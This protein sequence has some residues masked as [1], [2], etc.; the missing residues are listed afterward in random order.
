MCKNDPRPPSASDTAQATFEAA[1][2][3]LPGLFDIT[4]KAILPNEMATLEA[5]KAVQPGYTQLASDILKGPGSQLI[6][7]VLDESKKI[8]TEFFAARAAGGDAMTRLLSSIDLSGLLSGSEAAE[9]ERNLNRVDTGTG[10]TVG[11]AINT[12]KNINEYGT[13]STAKKEKQQQIG[14]EALGAAAGFLP[15]SRVG[16]DP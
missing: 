12:A 4:N 3:Y 6:G 9:M 15:A 10:N 5:T 11:S 8:D 13:A 2:K 7:G 1:T 16:I 14:T